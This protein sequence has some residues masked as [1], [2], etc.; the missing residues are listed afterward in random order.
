MYVLVVVSTIFTL[1]LIYTGTK[2]VYRCWAALE[3]LNLCSNLGPVSELL[4]YRAGIAVVRVLCCG[5]YFLTVLVAVLV[6][7]ICQCRKPSHALCFPW[8]R[9]VEPDYDEQAYVLSVVLHIE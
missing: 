9:T 1:Y 2:V 8:P 6:V 7:V 5:A 4:D 3:T